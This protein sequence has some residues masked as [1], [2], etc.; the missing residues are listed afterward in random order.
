MRSQSALVGVHN[1]PLFLLQGYRRCGTSMAQKSWMFSRLRYL[2]F[3]TCT[4]SLLIASNENQ[5]CI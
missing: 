3:C 4:R 2:V 1:K 5:P